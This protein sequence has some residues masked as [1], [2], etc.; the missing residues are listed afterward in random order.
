MIFKIDLEKAYDHV[1]WSFIMYMMRRFGF[2]DKWCR[3]IE[4]CISSTSFFVLVNGSPSRLFKASPGIRQRDPL[5][6]FLFTMV[7]EALHAPL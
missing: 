3:W 2:G 4:E 7:A 1:E 5:S 6:L